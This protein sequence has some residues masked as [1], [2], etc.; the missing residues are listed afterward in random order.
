[1]AP[2]FIVPPQD[3]TIVKDEPMTQLQC[4]VNARPLHE[5]QLVWLKDGVPVEQSGVPTFTND[6]WNRTL[7]LITVGF[8]HAGTYTCHARM[9]TGGSQVAKSA[10]VTV[11]GR[12]SIL[13]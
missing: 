13:L 10:Q 7:S 1:M 9:R 6:V 11:I 2:E 12:N 5:L 8:S 3:V 4:I